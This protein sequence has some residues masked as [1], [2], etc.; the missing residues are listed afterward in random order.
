MKALFFYLRIFYNKH[1]LAH[2]ISSDF[3]GSPALVLKYTIVY[4]NGIIGSTF[5]KEI[6]KRYC[7]TIKKVNYKS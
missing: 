3:G 7:S 1:C 4:N 5:D 2:V 6:A